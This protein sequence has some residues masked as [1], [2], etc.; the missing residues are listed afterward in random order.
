[1]KSLLVYFQNRRNMFDFPESQFNKIIYV[2]EWLD[3]RNLLQKMSK[4]NKNTKVKKKG[5]STVKDDSKLWIIQG[6]ASS[7]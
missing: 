5:V 2:E 6:S 1:M 7:D 4:Q 3:K